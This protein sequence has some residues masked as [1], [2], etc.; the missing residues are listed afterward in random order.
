MNLKANSVGIDSPESNLVKQFRFPVHSAI[1]GSDHR[2]PLRVLESLNGRDRYRGLG[3]IDGPRVDG[4]KFYL[5]I[6]R[7]IS[8]SLRS[9]TFSAY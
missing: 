7:R 9:Q 8:S 1:Y 6:H 2:L 3:I 4:L 5:P